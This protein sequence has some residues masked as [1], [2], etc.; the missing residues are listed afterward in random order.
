MPDVDIRCEWLLLKIP[1]REGRSVCQSPGLIITGGYSC[2]KLPGGHQQLGIS[3]RHWLHASQALSAF[4]P[5]AGLGLQRWLALSHANHSARRA[6][7]HGRRGACISRAPTA[8][9]PFVGIWE[10]FKR[11][12]MVLII[13]FF[14]STHNTARVSWGWSVGRLRSDSVN[15]PSQDRPTGLRKADDG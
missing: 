9:L 3:G 13:S 11:E 8:V 2:Q 5:L 7:H 14:S 10:R 12:K 4:S 6:A 1:Q 15:G